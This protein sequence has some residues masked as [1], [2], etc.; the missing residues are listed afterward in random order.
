MKSNN[1]FIQIA[2]LFVFCCLILSIS[3]C[4][5]FNNLGKDNNK[6][7]PITTGK[8]STKKDTLKVV[9]I[10]P[11]V[12]TKV[13]TIV[14]RDTLQENEFKKLVI[15][16]TKIGKNAVQK[17]T[18][19]IIDISN[20]IETP[21]KTN[22]ERAVRVKPTYNVAVIMP[23]MTKSYNFKSD[24]PGQSLRA[25]EFYEGMK[26]AFDS[27]EKEG[28]RLNVTVYDSQRDAD[29]VGEILKKPELLEADLIFGPVG[30]SA[31]REVAKFGFENGIPVVSAFNNNPEV[32]EDNHYFIQS[33][34]SF[35]TQS[36]YIATFLTK[37]IKLPPAY[38]GIK[39]INYLMLGM[40]E[41]TLNMLEVQK[42][43]SLAKN[44]PKAK[45]PQKI[46]T[47]GGFSIADLRSYF[48]RDAINVVIVPSYRSETF[49]NGVLR[50]LSAM[51]DLVESKNNHEF[52]VIGMPQWKYYERVNFEY[53]EKLKLHIPDN[54][55]V[56]ESKSAN[57]SF[58]DGYRSHYGIAPREFAYIG[59]DNMLYFGRLLKK[60]G[61]AFP[62]KFETEVGY[63]RHTKF[64][65][66]PMMRVRN[67]M[68]GKNV[69]EDMEIMRFENQYINFLEF[70]EYQFQLI[71]MGVLKEGVK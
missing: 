3:S 31:L 4:G 5:L 6:L 10:E 16:Y 12:P 49:V 59:F 70:K 39:K 26:I 44:D 1:N 42:A 61:T 15:Q 47:A 25:V 66:E 58:R 21:N 30:T 48:S 20:T 50:E 23:F 60:Y 8:D 7:E 11:P 18:L 56:D 9:R 33:N 57:I 46:L 55:Y 19:A 62:D 22:Q 34:P 13:D 68:D 37:H 27:L 36:R 65:Y 24:L 40:A 17:D 28:V 63:G 38:T 69:I 32:T 71:D 51:L 45:L 41:D 53:Y 52:I 14:W 43:Y 29:E 2:P 54:Y 35:A 67:I 64:Y